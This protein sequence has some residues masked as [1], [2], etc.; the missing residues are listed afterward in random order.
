MIDLVK[1]VDAPFLKDT[2]TGALVSTDVSGLTAYKKAKARN[3]L[4]DSVDTDI[5]TLKKEVSDIKGLLTTILE[6]LDNR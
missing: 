1:V 2:K 6:R 5:N 4:I 3:R